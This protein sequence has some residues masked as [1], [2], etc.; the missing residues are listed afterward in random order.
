MIRCEIVNHSELHQLRFLHSGGDTGGGD[1]H[2][3]KIAVYLQ[4]TVT[5]QAACVF[6]CNPNN[7]KIV[8]NKKCFSAKNTFEV[9]PF[10]KLP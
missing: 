10:S 5:R 4:S 6:I 8:V 9:K 1:G 7:D 3:A 2:T